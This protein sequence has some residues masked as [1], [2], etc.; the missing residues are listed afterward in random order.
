[1]ERFR[2]RLNGTHGTRIHALMERRSQTVIDRIGGL[3]ETVNG[4]GSRGTHSRNASIEPREI[5]NEPLS[6]GRVNGFTK[7]NSN[8]SNNATGSTMPRNPVIEPEK[9]STKRFRQKAC[10]RASND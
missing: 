1:M 5:F 4:I 9:S 2:S 8:Q 7:G 6:R 10:S 3:V